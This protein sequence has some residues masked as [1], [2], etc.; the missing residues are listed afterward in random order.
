MENE[1]HNPLEEYVSTFAPRFKEVVEQTFSKL[2]AEAKVDIT[3]NQNTCDEIDTLEKRV[4]TLRNNVRWLTVL[5]VFIWSFII[6]VY[7]FKFITD[8][9]FSKLA[10]WSI[11]AI[12]FAA[13]VLLI[14]KIHPL[15][16]KYRA[17]R[18]SLSEQAETLRQQAWQ[19]MEPLNRLY[20]WDMLTRMIAKTIPCIEFDHFFTT[21]RLADLKRFYDW[22]ED[23]NSERSV[24]YS[25]SGLINGNPFIICRTRKM[26]ME[27]KT[28][29]GSK[30]I[31]W[32]ER[33]RDSDGKMQTVT[34]SQ[35]L[36]AYVTAPCPEYYEKTRLIYGN[37]AAPDLIFNRFKSGL[38]GKEGS[39]A[40]KLKRR[41]LRKKSRDLSRSNFAM[42]TNE[43][44]EVAFDSS[45]RNNNQQFALL[46]TPL[47][48]INMMALLKDKEIGYG[49]DFNFH[50]RKMI[51]TLVPDHLQSIDLDIN[52]TQ[53]HHF[54]VDKAREVFCQI[55]SEC[56]RAIYFAFAPLLTVPMYQ[57]IRPPKD[58]FGREMKTESCYWE[59]ESLANFWG[60]KYFRHPKCVTE[61]ILKTH[62]T[63][64]SSDQKE[65]T[66]FAHGFRV[67]HRVTYIEKNGDDG[68]THFVPVRWDEYFPV[69]GKGTMLLSH[70]QNFDDERMTQSER[71]NHI[72]SIVPHSDSKT[73]Y[74]HH[75]ISTILRK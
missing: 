63:G 48:Q 36:Y 30:T 7:L 57:Q 62:Q 32:T 61:C 13:F 20:D 39:V 67:E 66:V 33:E 2:V 42:M 72:N 74:R 18:D 68:H 5:Q 52:P 1:I 70:D 26:E 10:A 58:Y 9:K 31:Y 69:T 41:K 24:I 56:F 35:V 22:D 55:N 40:H 75:I 6:G 29:E 71:I 44:F 16:K 50:K 12:N 49:D 17:E 15:L 28:Y 45:D 46:F 19:Q 34:R 53:F 60:N 23:F 21:Q 64:S 25:H 3:A 14:E 38:A 4:K 8:Y 47:A 51:N 43:D 59:H 37:T 27:E 73:V 54:S 11:S 65:I